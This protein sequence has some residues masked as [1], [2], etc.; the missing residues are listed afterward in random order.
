M[1]KLFSFKEEK[2]TLTFHTK[3]MLSGPVQIKIKLFPLTI[4][5]RSKLR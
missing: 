5:S 3:N 1:C 4:Q 2:H